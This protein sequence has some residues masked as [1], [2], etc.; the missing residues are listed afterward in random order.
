MNIHQNRGVQVMIDKDEG[1]GMSVNRKV[2]AGP[3]SVDS[4]SDITHLDNK[5]RRGSRYT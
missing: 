1:Q 3:V 5:Q 2:A 4:N